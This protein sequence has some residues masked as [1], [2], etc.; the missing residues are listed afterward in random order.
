MK[1][2]QVLWDARNG[3]TDLEICW[4]PLKAAVCFMY[5]VLEGGKEMPIPDSLPNNTPGTNN[6]SQMRK[7][8][9]PYYGFGCLLLVK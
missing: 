9:L 2:E 3:N 6:I 4:L 1:A 5:A 8:P 7:K